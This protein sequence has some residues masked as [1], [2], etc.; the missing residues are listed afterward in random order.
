MSA[1]F[2]YSQATRQRVKEEFPDSSFGEVVSSHEPVFL[3]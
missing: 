2:L 1:F 3:V